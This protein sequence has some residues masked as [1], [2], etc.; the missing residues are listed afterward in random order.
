MAICPDVGLSN[1]ARMLRSVVFPQ[2]D[3]PT[4]AQNSP[5]A[6][7]RVIPWRATT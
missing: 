5:A 7:S 3:G 4:T 6:I 1:P 2:P